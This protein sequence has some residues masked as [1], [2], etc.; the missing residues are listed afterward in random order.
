RLSS[1]VFP[2]SVRALQKAQPVIEYI[3]PYSPDLAGWITKFGQGASNYDANGHY[4]RIQPIF[5]EFSLGNVP[6]GQLLTAQSPSQRLSGLEFGK[7]RRCPGGA[8]QPPPDGSAP[9]QDTGGNTDCD[10]TSVPP[11]P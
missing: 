6:G 5:N 8:T 10:P 1:S 11:G 4:A 7:G 2:R 3:R 9:W